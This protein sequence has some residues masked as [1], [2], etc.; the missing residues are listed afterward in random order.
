[1][2]SRYFC[3]VKYFKVVMRVFPSSRNAGHR[4]VAGGVHDATACVL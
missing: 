2:M 3:S 4:V 1:M